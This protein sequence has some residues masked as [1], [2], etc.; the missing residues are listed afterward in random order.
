M[1]LGGAAKAAT[2][3]MQVFSLPD[4][5]TPRRVLRRW[6]DATYPRG[7]ACHNPFGVWRLGASGEPGEP[8]RERAIVFMP[9]L[10]V[11]LA[12]VEKANGKPLTRKQ[13]EKMTREAP[14]ITMEHAEAAKLQRE[15]G[16]AD[17][18]PDH[19]WEQW[20]I[21]RRTD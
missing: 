18:D 14:C 7:H 5:Q 12:A 20:Q 6:P 17:L 1:M 2:C 8:P 9:A 3:G 13:V 16:Y 11:F 21:A 19:A 4:A 15:R 10:A